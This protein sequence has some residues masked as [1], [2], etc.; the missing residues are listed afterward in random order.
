MEIAPETSYINQWT[1]LNEEMEKAM[2]GQQSYVAAAAN[3][4]ERINTILRAE[5]QQTQGKRFWGS[6]TSYL[7]GML[8]LVSLA[9]LI[10]Q[11]QRRKMLEKAN[12]NDIL[13]TG[14]E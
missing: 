4:Q 3:A 2:L 7:A 6:R 1:I 5:R 8:V 12:K 10:Y 14:A 9:G 13:P 11:S